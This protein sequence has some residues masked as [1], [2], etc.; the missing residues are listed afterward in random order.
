MKNEIEAMITDITVTTAEAEDYTGEDGLLY[1][2]K[3]HTPKEAYFAEG[4]TCFGRDRHPTDYDCHRAAREKQ[5]AA[6]RQGTPTQQT[7]RTK[8]HVSIYQNQRDGKANEGC[9]QTDGCLCKVNNF[10]LEVKK[11]SFIQ[12]SI[13]YTEKCFVHKNHLANNADCKEDYP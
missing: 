5:Q 11:D 13:F 1:C 4:K 6:E 10:S 7:V 9:C 12:S 8:P 3:C 2:G